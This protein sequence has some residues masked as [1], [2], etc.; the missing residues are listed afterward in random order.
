MNPHKAPDEVPTEKAEQAV[1]EVMSGPEDGRLI[2][3]EKTPIS[4][5]RASDNVV[6]LPYDHMISR[7]HA[8]IVKS[9]GKFI[10]QDLGSTNGTFVGGKRVRESLAIEPGELFCVGATQLVLRPFSEGPS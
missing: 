1:V 2:V 4:M 5:G 10:L 3:C 6:H 7:H 8:K 9:K